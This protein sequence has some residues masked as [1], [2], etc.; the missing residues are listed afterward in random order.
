[1]SSKELEKTLDAL[2]NEVLEEYD[3]PTECTYLSIDVDDA[4]EKVFNDFD[5][6]L[7]SIKSSSLTT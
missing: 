3:C 7:T 1:M 4:Q 6:S 5:F 2:E